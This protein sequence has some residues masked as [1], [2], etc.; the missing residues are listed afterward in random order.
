[1]KSVLGAGFDVNAETAA[2][3]SRV[4]GHPQSTSDAAREIVRV[5]VQGFDESGFTG[6]SIGRIADQAGITKSLVTYYF[7]TKNSLAIAILQ[8]A[9]SGG[10]FLGIRRESECPLRAIIEAVAHA[11]SRLASDAVARVALYLCDVPELEIKRQPERFHGW[12]PRIH[13]YLDEAQRRGLIDGNVEVATQARLLLAGMVGLATIA[14]QS[15][16][17][18]SLSSDVVQITTER[19]NQIASRRWDGIV[20]SG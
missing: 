9:N 4:R 14:M 11:A 12:L 16:E 18:S 10:V 13:D 7:P 20:P 17:F 3:R 8:R 1:M 15:R 19:L 2:P 5:A 6:T